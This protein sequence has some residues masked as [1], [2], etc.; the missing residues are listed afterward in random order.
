[1]K[2]LFILFLLFSATAKAQVMGDL[3]TDGRA[4]ATDIDYNLYADTTGTIVFNIAVDMDGKVTGC[5]LNND[6][7]T[8]KSTRLLISAKN[9]ILKQLSFEVGYAFPKHHQGQVQINVL[10]E[11]SDED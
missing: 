5:Q 3:A 10:R 6:K 11:E 8:L 2:K 9:R 1:M 4:I 7:T